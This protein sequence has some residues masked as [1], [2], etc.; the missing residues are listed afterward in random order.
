MEEHKKFGGPKKRP[1]SIDGIM[2]GGRQLGVPISRS[3]QPSNRPFIPTLG[4]TASQGDGFHPLRV[5]PGGLG[6]PESDESA[7][8]DEPIVLDQTSVAKKRHYFG[9]PRPKAQRILKRGILAVV[10]F[11]LMI[12]GYLGIKAYITERHLFHGGGRAPALAQ[13]VDINQL[14]GEGDGRINVLLLG[15]GGPGHD[16]P[17]LTDSMLLVSIDPINNNVAL[18]SIPRD[19]WVKIP[20]NGYQK[21]NAAY[22]YGKMGS[23]AKALADQEADGLKLLDQ[24][25]EPVLGIPIHYHAVVDFAAFRDVVNSLGGVTFNVPD[26]L[27][28]PTIAWENNNNP[29]IAKPGVQTMN[30][31]KALLYAKSRETSSDFA[32]GQRQRQLLVA[33]KDKALSAGTFSNPIKISNLLNSL[34]NN[35]YTDFSLN[36]V[37]R[38]YQITQKIPSGDVNSLDLVTPP[39]SLVTTGNI[40]GLSVV[41]PR[42]SL[43]DYSAIQNYVRNALK[44]GFIA[45]ENASVAVY[46]A[47]SRAGLAATKATLLKSYG[48]NVPTVDNAPNST[49]PPTTT[50]V[51]LTGGK[52]EYTRHYLEERF[53]V[54]AVSKVPSSFGIN[55]PAGTSFVIILGR[56]VAASG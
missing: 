14:K 4:Q 3:Y 22:A 18:L 44:D 17:D 35:V 21:I 45:K 1:P 2:S 52:D 26:Q 48:Y 41:E 12:G 10:V 31:Q 49:N 20:G 23:R 42:T 53:A 50:L 33:I 51:D 25:L 37:T 32:R 40:N 16:G 28:D 7:L 15:I 56:D 38:L 8:L 30:G 46:N 27:Y 24:T 29:V 13:N 55:P 47:T 11:F 54:T 36:D 19:L 34:G 5:A 39:Q 43:F 6:S 9:Q